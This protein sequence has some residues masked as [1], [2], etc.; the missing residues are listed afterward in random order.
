M[1]QVLENER[2]C[3]TSLFNNEV[4]ELYN[5]VEEYARNNYL[6]NGV[7]EDCYY[8]TYKD[9][10]YELRRFF[11][12]DILYSITRLKEFKSEYIMLENVFNGILTE[13]EKELKDKI[14]SIRNDIL[15]LHDQG[16]PYSLIRRSI[17]F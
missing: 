6:Y 5:K 15:S 14:D 8:V 17:K 13:S 4:E 16:V 9:K 3:T 1:Y 11:G 10:A 12:P 2:E 7:F